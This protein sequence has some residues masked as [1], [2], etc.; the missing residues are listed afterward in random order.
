MHVQPVLTA[1]KAE[2]WSDDSKGSLTRRTRAIVG[3]ETV[4]TRRVRCIAV[5]SPSHLFLAGEQMVP[6]H[7]SELTTKWNVV[8]YLGMFEAKR[9]LIVCVRGPRREVLPRGPRHLQ[10]WGPLLF[11]KKVRDDMSAVDEWGT[12]D[13]GFVRAV[14]AESKG[15]TGYGF[16]LIVIDDPVSDAKAARSE[17]M[18]KNLL[19][20][21]SGT[22]RTRLQPGGTMVLVMARWTDDDLSGTVVEKAVREGTGDPWKIIKISAI[23]RCPLPN[24]T[25]TTR[26]SP[27]SRL[28]APSG[29]TNGAL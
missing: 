18:K 19:E 29:V 6:T 20:W 8:W 2:R 22:L 21:Y 5:D 27:R 3:F 16:D 17:V 7:N 10:T 1:T 26:I 12:S 24:Q 15:I 28:S 14:G 25:L 9:I 4:G 23:A 11:G 13:G